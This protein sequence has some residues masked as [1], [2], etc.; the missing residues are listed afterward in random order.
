[1]RP[2]L[3]ALEDLDKCLPAFYYDLNLNKKPI[4]Q[5]LLGFFEEL[6]LEGKIYHD[7]HLICT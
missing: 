5:T 2:S 4:M 1:M 6:S 7:S 3:Y